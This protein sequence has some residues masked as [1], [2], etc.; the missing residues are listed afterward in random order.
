MRTTQVIMQVVKFIKDKK[1][2]NVIG[3]RKYS[4]VVT[5]NNKNT[6]KEAI[7]RIENSLTS[8]VDIIKK[9]VDEKLDDLTKNQEARFKQT[10][11]ESIR[12]QDVII[13]KKNSRCN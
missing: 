3:N 5:S 1:S 9:P 4:Q 13:E 12:K 7:T 2:G 6:L 10:L 8:I 11:D